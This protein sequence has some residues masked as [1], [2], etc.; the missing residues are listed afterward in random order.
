MTSRVIIE[1][2]GGSRGNPGPAS[3]GALVRDADTG[4]VIA[5]RGV[6]IGVA[7]NNVAEYSGLIA[8]LELV[9]EHAPDA[10][11][12]VRMDSKLVIEQMAGRW[13]I[14][15]ADMR[16]LAQQAQR[17]VP[18]GVTWTWVPRERNK[19]ADALANAALDDQRDG[20]SGHVSEAAPTRRSK[21]AAA[22]SSTGWG[23]RAGE[24][25]TV[26]LLRHGV[27]ESTERK[28]FCGTGGA[29]PGL[30]QTGEEQARRAA[31]WL[32]RLGGVDAIVASPLQRTRETAAIVS[33]ELSIEVG[34]EAGF[35]E[36]S[37]GDWDGY[38]FA[39]ILQK[40]PSEMSAWL[41]STA[42]A[43]PG[44][45][46]FD[47]VHTRVSEAR[48]RLLQ[49]HPGRTVVVVSHVTPIKMM[50]RQALDAPMRSIYQMELS[51]ASI[52]TISWWPDG[53]A[54]LR[55]FNTVPD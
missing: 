11:V 40:W 41:G 45:E 19:A 53:N 29:D 25:T 42:V 15:H 24:P 6:T 14:K 48:G 1:A 34:L 36:A 2:D 35:T 21:P 43:P 23:G 49:A 32:S 12:E 47:A 33:A 7:T 55:T 8:G 20:G 52:S 28:L 9:R 4:V 5:Q 51:P 27:T 26:I 10:Q 46:T 17:L 50:V 44:G 39:E 3:Y 38:S 22:A 54:S 16:P 30:T 31:A 13:K 37:F 18:P